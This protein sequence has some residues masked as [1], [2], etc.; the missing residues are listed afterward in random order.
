MAE[1][2]DDRFDDI[3]QVAIGNPIDFDDAGSADIFREFVDIEDL[4]DFEQDEDDK[5]LRYA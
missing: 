5:R 1:S 2:E 4:I 3:I